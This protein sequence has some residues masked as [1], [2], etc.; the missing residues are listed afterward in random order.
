MQ[1]S[2]IVQLALR[3]SGVLAQGQTA[4]GSM[5]QDAMDLL[6]AMVGQWAVKRWLVYHLIDLTHTCTGAKTYTVGAGGDFDVSVRPN[7]IDSCYVSMYYG[8]PN[9]IDRP[10]EIIPAREDYNRITLKSL[11]SYPYLAYYDNSIPLGTLYVWPIPSSLYTLTLSVKT[12]LPAE[13][14]AEYQEALI[15]NLAA[16]L[17]A[18]Y[19]M[20][21]DGAV[22]GLAKAALNTVRT[23]NAQV[24]RLQMPGGMG[25]GGNRFNIYTGQ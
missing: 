19:Q 5:N 1:I 7:E 2:R 3:A 23:A 17:R 9:Q 21:P 4:S 6:N 13:L 14:P 11:N 22:I 12:P 10:L 25:K 16:R 18:F 8:Q 24:Q 15:Y 20:E